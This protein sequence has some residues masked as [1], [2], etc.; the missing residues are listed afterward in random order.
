MN[1]RVVASGAA[2][3]LAL[4]A[5][6]AAT[7]GAV[8]ADDE[9]PNVAKQCNAFVT[10]WNAHDAKAM[11][12]IFGEDGDA[13]DPSGHHAV[14]KAAVEKMFL[15]MHTGQGPMRDSTLKVTDEPIR[16]PTA[17]IA[18][19]DASVIVTGAYGPD[20]KKAGPMALHVTDVW[21]KSGGTWMVFSCR[22]YMVATTPAAPP[23]PPK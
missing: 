20:G 7:R 22:P 14:G 11:T 8:G 9:T 4:A 12:A 1:V 16:F 15:G 13:I 19:S 6:F 21:K 3:C 2:L 23:S 10:A 17:D 18:V 5:G